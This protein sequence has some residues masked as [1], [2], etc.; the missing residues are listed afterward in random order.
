MDPLSVTAS[1]IAV[2]TLAWQSCKA[3]YDFVDGL[4]EAPR[5]IDQSKNSLIETQKTLTALQ[6]ALK[7]PEHAT[8]LNSVLQTIE[9]DGTLKS[10][11]HVCDEFIIAIRGFTTHSTDGKL[12]KRDR[13]TVTLHE[14]KITKF[15][16]QLGDCQRTISMVLKSINL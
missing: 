5:A 8:A 11:Q 16:M 10:V 1:V 7:A 13:L 6:G 2:T 15:N 12:S 3:A 9:L 14:S 4:A